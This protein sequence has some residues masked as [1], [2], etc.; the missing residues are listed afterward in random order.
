MVKKYGEK[1]KIK[2]VESLTTDQKRDLMHLFIV[3]RPKMRSLDDKI[4]EATVEAV[5]RVE[6]DELFKSLDI[7]FA[8]IKK[9]DKK[10]FEIPSDVIEDL[11]ED[12]DRI[13]EKQFK[14]FLDTHFK[15]LK[16]FIRAG[17]EKAFE[18]DSEIKSVSKRGKELRRAIR[19]MK[20]DEEYDMDFETLRSVP[21]F[22]ISLPEGKKT[23]LE[24]NQK[25]L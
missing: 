22:K 16:E 24:L 2:D 5:R 25:T 4:G 9:M 13:D 8:I 15:G 12:K 20:A 19:N 7:I 21:G 14:E 6:D 11:T 17:E 23:F 1:L 18:L 3:S 10:G